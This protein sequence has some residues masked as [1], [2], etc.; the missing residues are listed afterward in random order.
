MNIK[1]KS[2]FAGAVSGAIVFHI[3][4]FFILGYTAA[5]VLPGSIADWAKE[6]SMRFPV[7]LLWDLLVV[8]LLGI[9]ILAA[10]ASYLVVKVT[11]FQWFSVAVGFVVADIVLSYIY[12]LFIDPLQYFSVTHFVSSLPHFI[13]IFLCV[14]IAAKLAGK[15]QKV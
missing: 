13:V 14:F 11:R 2:L 15:N 9:G 7:L 8:Q 12:L 6:N 10:I 5:I 3:A 4:A 1:V